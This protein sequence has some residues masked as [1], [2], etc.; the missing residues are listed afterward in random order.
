M[1]CDKEVKK[2][3]YQDISLIENYDK[4]VADTEH[5]W[6]CH[7]RVETIMNCGAK[8]LIAQGCYYD[9]PAHDLIFLR[10]S[11][12]WTLHWKRRTLSETTLKKMSDRMR[13]NKYNKGKRLS[14]EAKRKMSELR[15]GENN[16]MFG[17]RHS[18]DTRKKMSDVHAG[19]TPWNKGKKHSEETK[20]KISEARKRYLAKRAGK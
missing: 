15:K 10:R 1:I 7:H 3:C 9:R 19:Q 20:R 17:K 11:D 14:E 5:V 18:K 12:H 2:Y 8:E 16:G 6:D 4:A 13:G